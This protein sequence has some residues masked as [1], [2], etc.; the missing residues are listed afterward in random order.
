MLRENRDV[1]DALETT[2]KTKMGTIQDSSNCKTV[3]GST[4]L[5]DETRTMRARATV[6]DSRQRKARSTKAGGLYIF[7]CSIS[8]CSILFSNR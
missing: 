7:F 3:N 2:E 4:E 6:E 1:G 5:K 8:F